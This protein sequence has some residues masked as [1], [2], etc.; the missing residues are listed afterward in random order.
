MFDASQPN[1]TQQRLLLA[2]MREAELRAAWR[3]ANRFGSRRP[4][5]EVGQLRLRGA[6]AAGFIR[7]GQAVTELGRAVGG[8]ETA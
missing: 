2:R 8:T 4:N 1:E 6:V 7:I 3:Q 5:R